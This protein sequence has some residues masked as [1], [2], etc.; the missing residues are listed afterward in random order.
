MI[1]IIKISTWLAAGLL[2]MLGAA[3]T[4]AQAPAPPTGDVQVFR[5][6]QETVFV[7]P[8]V[9]PVDRKGDLVGAGDLTGQVRQALVNLRLMASRVGVSPAHVVTLTVYGADSSLRDVMEKSAREA[10]SDWGPATAFVEAKNLRPAGALVEVEAVA[11]V[12]GLKPG[13]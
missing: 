10:F 13:K 11:V 7:F 1:R 12:R 4:F 5:N 3:W 9:G 2:L 6:A 8:R